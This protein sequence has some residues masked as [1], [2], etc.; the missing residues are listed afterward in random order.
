[1]KCLIPFILAV[2]LVAAE[3]KVIPES[4]GTQE[5]TATPDPFK[6]IKNYLLPIFGNLSSL[7]QHIPNQD[8]VFNT[9]KQQSTSLVNNMNEY[10]KNATDEVSNTNK[11]II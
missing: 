3:G 7:I 2:V 10:I 11:C 9:F 1:M 4:D 5:S 6:D 8:E